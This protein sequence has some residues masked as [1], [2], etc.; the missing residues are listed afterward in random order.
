MIVM[1]AGS[2]WRVLVSGADTGGLVAVVEVCIQAGY[3]PP[4]HVHS[5]EDEVVVVLDGHVL[6]HR[7]GEQIDC[8]A[9]SRVLLPRGSDHTFTIRSAAA[10]LL[11]LLL[12]AGLEHALQEFTPSVGGTHAPDSIELLVSTAA[13]YGVAITGP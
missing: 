12:P 7:D 9:G 3:E 4:H 2:H 6:V 5:R 13:R 10:R 1:P 8:K 11:L